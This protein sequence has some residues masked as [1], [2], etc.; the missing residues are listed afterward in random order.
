MTPEWAT[1]IVGT[2]SALLLFL[3]QLVVRVWGRKEAGRAEEDRIEPSSGKFECGAMDNRGLLRTN[4]DAVHGR[5][6]RLHTRLTT[7]E[8]L[9]FE[10]R[11]LVRG[12][13][14]QR[15][16]EGASEFRLTH[17]RETRDDN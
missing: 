9:Q 10:V 4:F 6:D 2:S 17:G 7:I 1:V 5:I 14:R 15:R 12:H 16:Q 3:G 8:E 11:D 13:D